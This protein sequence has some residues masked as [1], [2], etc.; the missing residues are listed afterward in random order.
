MEKNKYVAA[1][2]TWEQ[3]PIITNISNVAVG[4]EDMDI[5]INGDPKSRQYETKETLRFLRSAKVNRFTDV[6]E[7]RRVHA[8]MWKKYKE[9]RLKTYVRF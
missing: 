4:D 8:E 3:G 9:E 5:L 2:L 6:D 7:A 1:F